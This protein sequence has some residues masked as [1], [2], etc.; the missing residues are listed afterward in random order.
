MALQ[1]VIPDVFLGVIELKFLFPL[2]N[3]FLIT[4][5]LSIKSFVNVIYFIFSS[6]IVFLVTLVQIQE[7][8]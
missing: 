3:T 4:Q 5:I 1:I 8:V 2:N 7:T 6:F